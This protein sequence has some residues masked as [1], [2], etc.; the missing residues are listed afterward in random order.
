MPVLS[1][2]Q[3]AAMHAAA[4]GHSSLGIPQKVGAEFVAGQQPGALKSLPN[5]VHALSMASATHLH[6]M[7]HIT[8]EHKNQIHRVSQDMITASRNAA[9]RPMGMPGAAPA[10]P[11]GSMA[12]AGGAVPMARDTDRDG[13]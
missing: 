13:Y 7:G 12:P 4:E 11:W 9:Q 8:T 1:K 5:H 3:N 2:S 6:K 10:Q